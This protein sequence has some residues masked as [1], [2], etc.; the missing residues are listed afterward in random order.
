VF[1]LPSCS[2]WLDVKPESEV[3]METLLQTETGF[4]EALNGVYANCNT[5][6]MYG[7]LTCGFPDYLAG[8]YSQNSLSGKSNNEYKPF[9]TFN[10]TDKEAISKFSTTWK[11]MYKAV[12][13][14]NIII[15]KIDAK[16]NIFSNNNYE[17]I[18]GEALALRGY[19]YFDILRLYAPSFASNPNAKAI[20]YITEFSLKGAPQSTVSEVLD[21]ILT[22][23]NAGKALLKDKD[24]ILN[25]KYVIGYPYTKTD[26]TTELTNENLSNDIF[27]NS[28][29]DRL[30]YYAVCGELARVYLYKDD[31]TNALLNAK[32]VLDSNKFPWATKARITTSDQQ[33]KDKIF[34]TELVFGWYAPSLVDNMTA[35]FENGEQGLFSNLV[36]FN[37]AFETGSGGPGGSD[38]RYA[39]MYTLYSSGTSML[40]Y[41]YHTDADKKNMYDLRLPAI[42]LSEMY[43][44]AAEA[45]YDINPTQAWTYFNTVRFQR[46]IATT[47]S[48]DKTFFMSE[49][50]KEYRKEFFAEG[51][52]FYF[53]KRLN[54][55]I[56]AINGITTPASDNVFVIPIP[57]DEIQYGSISK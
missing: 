31:K 40:V 30:N 46:G 32:E 34:Y 55:P 39:N 26:E 12:A 48:G 25:A 6:S 36:Y 15:E 14:C 44:I 17:I 52:L 43:Y 57:D 41:K 38:M 7:E 51:Q 49:L 16:K 28:R 56:V 29:R 42:R 35:K 47:L 8:L 53:F 5:A 23:L 10:Y 45:I 33:Y 13:L 27:F 54:A 4:Q 1:I 9:F 50:T 2:K 20:P 19:L 22:D 11:S 37:N 24:P 21:K 3:D 18:K